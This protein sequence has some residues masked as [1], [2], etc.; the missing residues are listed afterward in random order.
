MNA[1]EH[2]NKN[3]P[4]RPVSI[5]VLHSH[6]RLRVQVTDQSE[7]GELPAAEVPDIEAKLAGLQKPRGWGLFLIESMVDETRVESGARGHTLE[8]IL[9]LN[10]GDTDGDE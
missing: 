2:G 1:I 7:A 6:G 10:E 5:R 9:H 8:L 3:V 4:E